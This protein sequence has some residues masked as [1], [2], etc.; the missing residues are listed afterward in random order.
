[1]TRPPDT[2]DAASAPHPAG[3]ASDPATPPRK[4]R[5]SPLARRLVLATVVFGTL[6]ALVTTAIQLYVD[7]RRELGQIS[8]TF[9]QI[10]H[11][12]QPTITSALWATNRAELQIALDGL[13]R[14]P[15]V[16]YAAVFEG[17][18][19]WA[20]SGVPKREH[21]QWRDYALTHV[22]RGQTERIGTLRVV[23][24]IDGLYGRL[25]DKFW[26]ILVTNSVKTLTVSVFMLWLF[27][28]LVTRHL[29][30]IADFASRLGF[31]T[32]G[33]KLKLARTV[34]ADK[35]EFDMLV[36][37]FGRMQSSLSATLRMLEDDIAQRKQTE[38]QLKLAAS[39]FEHSQ[40]GIMITDA[41]ANILN[42]N[43][44]FTRITGYTRE[45]AV[46]RNPK[47]LSADV[48]DQFWHERMW[49][50]LLA[51]GYWQGERWNRRK[52][53]EVYPEREAISAVYDD[54]GRVRHYVAVFSDISQQKA[55]EAEL[56]R[57]AHHDPLTGL[58]N[59]RLLADRLAQAMAR[60]QRDGTLL[61]VACLDLDGFKPVNDTYGHAAG[62][63]LLIEISQRLKTTL[64]GDDTLARLGGDE[65]VLLLSGHDDLEASAASIERILA[66]VRTPV[67][68]NGQAIEV[69]ASVGVAHFP[70]ED[71]DGDTLLRHADQAM[72]AAKQAGKNCFTVF[73]PQ[74]DRA[75]QGQ[76]D[77][78]Q[79]LALALSDDEFLFHFQPKV[80]LLTGELV[81]VEALIRWQHPE[82]GLLYPGAFLDRFNG[83][84]LELALG[85]WVIE[86]AL[87]QIE[88]WQASGLVLRI[89][90]NISANHLLHPDFVTRLTAVLARHPTVSPAQLELEVLESAAMSDL[91]RAIE[92]IT[93]CKR[94]GVQFALD[95][96]GTG[97]SSLA[98]FR[99]LP[100]DTLK[101]DQS[102][103]RDMLV[104]VEDMAIVESVVKLAQVFGRATLAEGVETLEHASRLIEMGCTQAQ[105]YGIARPMPAAALPAWIETWRAEA[106]WKQYSGSAPERA[107]F[108]RTG[109]GHSA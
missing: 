28:W 8:N 5:I 62:D 93:L 4:W 51:E 40:E 82:R 13:V 64:R 92:V 75:L 7:Y 97:Y 94:I 47:M 33:E 6:V 30:H 103:V 69:S 20:A 73:D 45:E 36:D 99:R 108:S 71:I 15:D 10:S 1:M 104:D 77:E 27:N 52:N 41:G 87:R 106:L 34:R 55:H 31:R 86:T 42:V 46:G 89:S 98:Y 105:G 80:D 25:L 54:E 84:P 70:V 95:D 72:Y 107:A 63:Q 88:T 83:H 17:A 2:A 68:L 39:V 79:R 29:R 91:G 26:V 65:F 101:I 67:A 56:D 24:D 38:A 74:H 48:H 76:R 18:A 78:L 59:R 100:V 16:Q 43:P 44:S 49:E 90:V 85:Q 19:L 60:A 61:T 32:L 21:I 96:F 3:A 102:F 14:L 81:G 109:A 50:F 57:I 12:H 58:P 53:G 37:G 9:R 23:I 22:H 11:S 35:D 66:T